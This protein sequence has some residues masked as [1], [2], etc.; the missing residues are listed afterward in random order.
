[1]V[2]PLMTWRRRCKV[3]KKLK[4]KA[5]KVEDKKPTMFGLAEVV[6]QDTHFT[7]RYAVRVGNTSVAYFDEP[8]RADLVKQALNHFRLSPAGREWWKKQCS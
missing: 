3:K 4:A 6:E 2:T 1:M 7:I 8:M 5:V